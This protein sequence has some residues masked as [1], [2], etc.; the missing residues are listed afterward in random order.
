MLEGIYSALRL[1]IVALAAC[2]LLCIFLPQLNNYN[3]IIRIKR[4]TLLSLILF[5]LFIP[6]IIIANMLGQSITLF[7]I[8]TILWALST[9]SGFFVLKEKK[10]KQVNVQSV[11]GDVIDLD[12]EE[13]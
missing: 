3:E 10:K 8:C 11:D 6:T 4:R 7:I 12:Y 5:V 13:L 9:I 1:V 2:Y